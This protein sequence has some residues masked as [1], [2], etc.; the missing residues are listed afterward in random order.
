MRLEDWR[1]ADE[2]AAFARTSHDDVATVVPPFLDG[3]RVRRNL[4]ALGETQHVNV[5]WKRPHQLREQHLVVA[6]LLPSAPPAKCRA[7]ILADG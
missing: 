4:G 2:L 6:R 3:I 5:K 1:R 7:Q